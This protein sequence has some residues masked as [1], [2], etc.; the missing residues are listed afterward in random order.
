MSKITAR[1]VQVF[2]AGALT[3]V[4][5]HALIRVGYNVM[6]AWNARDA[7]AWAMVGLL[8][9]FGIGVLL[10]SALALRLAQI[11]LWIQVCAGFAVIAGGA[12]NLETFRVPF[13]GAYALGVVL[14]TI[15]LALLL[16]SK[17]RR[18]APRTTP[19]QSLESTAGRCTE[20]LKDEL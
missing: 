1:D 20:R 12:F 14:D 2:V 9:P 10:G 11:Y 18:F 6:I 5:F 8:F 17:S 4:G 15:L 3:S 13:P 7:T 16:W 19:N